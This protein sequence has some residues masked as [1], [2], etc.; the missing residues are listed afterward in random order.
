MG[1][2][3]PPVIALLSSTSRVDDS[4][5]ARRPSQA[6]GMGTPGAR[7]VR[8]I[9]KEPKTPGTGRSV[10]FSSSTNGFRT[11]A[12]DRSP[13]ETRF[14][15]AEPSWGEDDEEEDEAEGDEED[16]T[17]GVPTGRERETSDGSIVD[18]GEPDDELDPTLDGLSF[19]SESETNNSSAMIQATFLSKLQAVIPSP[20]NSFADPPTL[21]FESPT[22]PAVSL[23]LPQQDGPAEDHAEPQSF[24][25]MGRSGHGGGLFDESNPFCSSAEVSMNTE[26][27]W[28]GLGA[29]GL[30]VVEEEDEEVADWSV[31]TDKTPLKRQL[32]VQEST[33]PKDDSFEDAM[34]DSVQGSP[35]ININNIHP[36][37]HPTATPSRPSPQTDHP[38]EADTPRPASPT[39]NLPPPPA[40][41]SPIQEH[42]QPKSVYWSPAGSSIS[43]ASA[44][45]H[46]SFATPPQTDTS[47]RSTRPTA[48]F[49]EFMKRRASEVGGGVD[50]FGR[51][52]GPAGGAEE[53]ETP[54]R[55]RSLYSTPGAEPLTPDG[56]REVASPSPS[57]V[58]VVGEAAEPS[59]T[60]PMTPAVQAAQLDGGEGEGESD[61]VLGL[62]VLSPISE[63]TEPN[64]TIS[65]TSPYVNATPA[66]AAVLGHSVTPASTAAAGTV[67]HSTPASASAVSIPSP[68]AFPFDHSLTP[69]DFGLVQ[70]LLSTT[71]E[72]LDNSSTQKEL[73]VAQVEQLHTELDRKE[74]MLANALA[75]KGQIEYAWHAAVAEATALERSQAADTSVQ[76]R[77]QTKLETLEEYHGHLIRELERRVAQDK[78][79]E[80]ARDEEQREHKRAMARAA[81]GARE[82]EIRL[83]HVEAC[84]RDAEE[85]RARVE[86]E[87]EGLR[88][89]AEATRRL[90]GEVQDRERTVLALRAELARREA[91]PKV[92]TDVD[93]IDHMREEAEV[94]RRRDRDD[95]QAELDEMRELLNAAREEA[96][97]LRNGGNHAKLAAARAQAEVEAQLA[98]LHDDLA[99]VARTNG[100]LEQ[101]LADCQAD[102]TAAHVERDRLVDEA[103]TAADLH[104]REKREMASNLEAVDR[105]METTAELDHELKVGGRELALAKEEVADLRDRCD[106]GEARLLRLQDALA[107]EVGKKV[108]AREEGARLKA[109]VEQ[110]KRNAADREGKLAKL[111]R[112]R[113]ELEEDVFG[114]NLALEAKQQEAAL[115]KRKAGAA[116][117]NK[118]LAAGT[119]ATASK[120]ARPLSM[121]GLSFLAEATEDAT[122]IRPAR[123]AGGRDR[124][125]ASSASTRYEPILNGIPKTPKG[126]HGAGRKVGGEKENAR[127]V[128]VEGASSRRRSVAA[129]TPAGCVEERRRILA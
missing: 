32:H 46:T 51:I 39:F 34:R 7:T 54:G 99:D 45:A 117:G 119:T 36:A 17:V 27:E 3:P 129:G 113:E 48:F 89:E 67:F 59:L 69:S 68:G 118:T 40:P 58:A 122:P 4:P 28:N 102:L 42:P 85:G 78:E 56:E 72:V 26:A 18:H 29:G 16:E 84:L 9:L 33:S 66:Y 120:L 70:S 63:R 57:P 20:D 77:R 12:D 74:A 80:R 44:L 92:S 87:C 73:L 96:A 100:L 94:Q 109:A 47:R 81:A 5:T 60:V 107:A 116:A 115:W 71:G 112:A 62:S 15:D 124:D 86:D 103:G 93:A 79:A 106:D 90:R 43:A 19:A 55:E 111:R 10:R 97:E 35:T 21:T 53:A 50:E 98:Q 91:N 49:K 128:V 61:E 82:G 110:L 95:H 23:L 13:V 121:G 25:V 101:D 88:V 125:T 38:T 64:T 114:L 52:V 123:G 41:V 65:S 108:A 37:D 8:P 75:Q 104:A 14:R 30:P 126:V 2:P 6:V 1:V 24:S 105:L 11:D 127:P 22:G 83:R 76:E 31:D